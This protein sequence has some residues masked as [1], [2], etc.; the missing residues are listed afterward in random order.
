VELLKSIIASSQL[1]LT[2]LAT[3]DTAGRVCRP[4]GHTALQLAY[5]HALLIIAPAELGR[6]RWLP[7]E[8]VTGLPPQVGH[9]N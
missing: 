9:E 3:F 5:L 1:R 6:R 8:G 4:G 7:I 2:A